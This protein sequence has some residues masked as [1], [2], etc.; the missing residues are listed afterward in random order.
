MCRALPD[1]AIA[2]HKR[3]MRKR[4][5]ARTEH[6]RTHETRRHK[7]TESYLGVVLITSAGL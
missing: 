7:I 5:L 4:S 6:S 1:G 2:T 3:E